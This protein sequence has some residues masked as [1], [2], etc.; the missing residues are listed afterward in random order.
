MIKQITRTNSCS[1]V[2]IR[3]PTDHFAIKRSP[4]PL[5]NQ[6]NP[7]FSVFQ[8]SKACKP[9]QIMVYSR[10]KSYKGSYKPSKK[11]WPK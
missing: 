3:K 2:S 6:P 9:A 4:T 8:E 5:N 1:F 11:I 10:T 7:H